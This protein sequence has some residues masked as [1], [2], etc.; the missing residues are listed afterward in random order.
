[1]RQTSEPIDGI[2]SLELDASQSRFRLL[3]C[4]PLSAQRRNMG[5]A[6]SLPADLTAA[7]VEVLAAARAASVL[8]SDWLKLS[9]FDESIWNCTFGLRPNVM[10]QPACSLAV[11][12]STCFTWLVAGCLELM[13]VSTI[14][15]EGGVSSALLFDTSSSISSCSAVSGFSEFCSTTPA[16]AS[17][18]QI[19][20][21]YISL[22]SYCW[23]FR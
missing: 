9:M 3:H 5:M 4:V 23:E 1:M 7:Q 13:Q 10:E 2:E 12:F 6:R 8:A 21:E 14:I 18:K 11:S 17:V 19:Q 22:Y 16:D 15:I 20:R